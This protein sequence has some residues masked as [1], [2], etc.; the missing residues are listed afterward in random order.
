MWRLGFN[1]TRRD[2]IPD[3]ISADEKRIIQ[4]VRPFTWTS[5]ERILALIDATKYIVEN[6]IAGDIV[7]CGVWRGGSM[8]TVALTLQSLG[9]TKRRLVL[10]DTFSGMTPPTAQDK[11]FDGNSAQELLEK[12]PQNEGLWCYADE[13]DVRRNMTATGYPSDNISYIKGKVEDTI[14]QSLPEKICLL[15][16]DTDWFESTKHELIHLY[17]LLVSQ[18]LLIIDDYGHW[19]GARAATDEYFSSVRP[20]PFLHRI[21]YTGRLLVKS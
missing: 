20:K 16:L 18:G 11:Q 13:A 7:E 12:T 5:T 17:P 6:E 3:D 21:D 19:K 9:D 1:L 10:Y 4:T 14:P 2:Q 15:R 8:M